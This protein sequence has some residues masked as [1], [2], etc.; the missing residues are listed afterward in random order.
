M[1]GSAGCTRAA[2]LRRCRRMFRRGCRSGT[3]GASITADI[4]LS[5]Y[6]MLSRELK[7]GEY[8]ERGNML[9]VETM[10][11]IAERRAQILI[12]S[13]NYCIIFR[14]AKRCG[15]WAAVRSEVSGE[16]IELSRKNGKIR[17]TR[18]IL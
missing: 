10:F 3:L 2:S 17:W 7:Y 4:A 5:R 13:T 8:K 16:C 1:A 9:V 14:G 15:K 18:A 12:Y 6:G 11:F